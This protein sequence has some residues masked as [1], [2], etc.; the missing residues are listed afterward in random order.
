MAQYELN[1]RDYIRIFRKRKLIVI[2][3]SIV[4]TFLFIFY[5][6]RQVPYYQATAMVKYEERQ[7]VAGKPV[8]VQG[9][10]FIRIENGW[11]VESWILVD[12]MG[13]LQQLGVVPPSRG[14]I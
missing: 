13:L 1:L 9:T 5:S 12:Q 10:I 14:N 6:S 3:S 7:T 8:E 2:A 4:F 11:I